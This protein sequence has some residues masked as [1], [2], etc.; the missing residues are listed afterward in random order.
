MGHLLAKTVA[1]IVRRAR[2]IYE[3]AGYFDEYTVTLALCNALGTALLSKENVTFHRGQVIAEDLGTRWEG[4]LLEI[5][6]PGFPDDPND[7]PAKRL[8]DRLWQAYGRWD[9]P[10]FDNEG[11]PR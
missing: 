11:R 2:R 1:E 8:C 5:Q 6:A 7:V 10:L 4:N 9:C 3:L